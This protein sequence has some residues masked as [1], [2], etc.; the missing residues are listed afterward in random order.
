[1]VMTATR[2]RRRVA[3]LSEHASPLALLGSVDAG[4]QNVYVDEVSRNLV[5]H[6]YAVDVF[7][8]RDSPDPPAI[9]DWAPGV[10]VVN[11]AVGPATFV[12]KDDLW[13]LMPAFRDA[14]EQFVVETGARYSLLHGNFWMSGW[15]AAQLAT[16][17]CIPVVQIF[18]ATGK[19]KHRYQGEAD[20]S[21]TERVAI[22]HEVIR[23]VDR[24][25]AQCPAEEAELIDD[26][27]AD[28]AKVTVIPSAVNIDRYRPVARVEARQ[29]IGLPSDALVIGYIGRMLPRKDP[30]NIVRA[31]ALLVRD[32]DRPLT[33]LLVG[34]ETRDPDPDATPEI[35]ELQ[36]LAAE[37]GVADRLLFTGK[38]QPDELR[39]YYSAVDV[40]VTTPWYEPFGLTPLEAMA[41]GT[42]V[43]GSAVGGITYTIADGETGFLVPPRDP[44]ALALRLREVLS[45]ADLRVRMS[46]AARA[47][48]ERDFTWDIV[49]ARTAA[50]YDE[51][52]PPTIES[53]AAVG[54]LSARIAG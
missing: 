42:P 28:P 16:R 5:R 25:I 7:T 19:T 38:R 1:M 46:R 30:R 33:L 11:L 22:E 18:H 45:N 23:S 52:L 14:V 40:A 20:T 39:D 24:I 3:F 6:G 17:L 54:N 41:C 48:V 15:V 2:A 49:A 13:P 29:R 31:L 8:R 12:P 43:I 50:L 4:G 26:Y 32:F 51:L 47:R 21:P 27:G 37:L 44:D 34:G 36:R 53:D 9:V 10:R 35:G